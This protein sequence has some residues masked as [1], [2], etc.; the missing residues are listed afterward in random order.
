MKDLKME[1]LTPLLRVFYENNNTNHTV[2]QNKF[3]ALNLSL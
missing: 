2:I 1:D 3:F